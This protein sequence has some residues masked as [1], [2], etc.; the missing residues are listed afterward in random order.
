MEAMDTEIVL[1]EVEAALSREKVNIIGTL[2]V[3]ITS[4]LAAMLIDM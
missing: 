2:V 4:S 1:A 3:H